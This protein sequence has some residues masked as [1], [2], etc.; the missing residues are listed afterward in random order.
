MIP[1]DSIHGPE[2]M[3]RWDRIGRDRRPIATIDHQFAADMEMTLKVVS[4]NSL[5]HRILITTR[6][7]FL[8]HLRTSH[9]FSAGTKL[10]EFDDSNDNN[11]TYV[12]AG[13]APVST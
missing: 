13:T 6:G 9:S 7:P 4:L 2:A 11:V 3:R 8:V 12:A 10:D 1:D 5:S